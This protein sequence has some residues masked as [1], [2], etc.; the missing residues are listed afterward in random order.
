MSWCFWISNHLTSR[1][2][3]SPKN[4]RWAFFVLFHFPQFKRHSGATNDGFVPIRLGNMRN[5]SRRKGKKSDAFFLFNLPG[6]NFPCLKPETCT[7]CKNMIYLITPKN[8]EG[9]GLAEAFQLW[10]HKAF[11]F[12]L[13]EKYWALKCAPLHISFRRPWHASK[14]ILLASKPD[15]SDG[16]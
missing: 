8:M 13:V 15:L 14:Y 1:M 7:Y 11:I 5:P 9:A 6:S 4:L 16:L 2:W 12:F 3:P 10:V